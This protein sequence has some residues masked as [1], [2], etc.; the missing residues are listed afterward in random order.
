MK[1]KSLYFSLSG[2]VSVKHVFLHCL[3]WRMCVCAQSLYSCLTLC[4][5]LDCSLSGSSI[6]GTPQARILQWVAITSSKELP[7][8][9]IKPAFP[10]APALQVDYLPLSYLG[11]LPLMNIIHFRKNFG[12]GVSK[13]II[14]LSIFFKNFFLKTHQHKHNTMFTWL[15]LWITWL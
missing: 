12:N 15:I 5:P 6:Y 7:N 13:T 11:K 1:S 2:C 8:P 3:H 9:G 4:H 14:E 10:M